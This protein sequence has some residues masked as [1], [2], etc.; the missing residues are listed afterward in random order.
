MMSRELKDQFSHKTARSRGEQKVK[1]L[2]TATGHITAR[3][4]CVRNRR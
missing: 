2:L 4:V 1:V 3:P